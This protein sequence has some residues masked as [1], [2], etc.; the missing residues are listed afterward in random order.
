MEFHDLP[1]LKLVFI[2]FFNYMQIAEADVKMLTEIFPDTA[3]SHIRH[4]RI[5]AGLSLDKVVEFLLARQPSAV[6]STTQSFITGES[7]YSSSDRLQ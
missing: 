1:P 5:N 2:F 7:C 6:R 3:V 4:M